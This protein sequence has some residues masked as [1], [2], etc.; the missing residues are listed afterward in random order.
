MKRLL[1]S[2]KVEKVTNTVGAV[3]TVVS[4]RN[5]TNFTGVVLIGSGALPGVQR[6][7]LDSFTTKKTLYNSVF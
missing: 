7:S 5:K 6:T 4:M 3:V 1:T 2:N